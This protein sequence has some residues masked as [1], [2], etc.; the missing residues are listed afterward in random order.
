MRPSWAFAR[1]VFNVVT[2]V[3]V[4]SLPFRV[5]L[6][7]ISSQLHVAPCLLHTSSDHVAP[8]AALE[9]APFEYE[10]SFN[11]PSGQAWSRQPPRRHEH[12]AGR[13]GLQHAGIR[14][15]TRFAPST[16]LFRWNHMNTS[17]ASRCPSR[18]QHDMISSAGSRTRTVVTSCTISAR[19]AYR[20]NICTFRTDR[21]PQFHVSVS[22]EHALRETVLLFV[23]SKAICFVALVCL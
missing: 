16:E 15:T 23:T 13:H 17:L 20:E 11:M 7:S 3:H 9:I 2:Y 4:P 21:S 10:N 5:S 14:Y 22:T 6:P 12:P 18:M 8:R 1:V 19:S